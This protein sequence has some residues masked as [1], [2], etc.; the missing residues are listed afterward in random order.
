VIGLATPP[1][2]IALFVTCPMADV[3]LE[4]NV[5]Q[6]IPMVLASIGVL[7]LITYVPGIVLWLPRLAGY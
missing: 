2:G 7:F 3:T 1:F 6:I 4:Q 5:R